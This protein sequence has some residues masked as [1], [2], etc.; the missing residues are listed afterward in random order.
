[1]K[2][3]GLRGK[4]SI[5]VDRTPSHRVAVVTAT[6]S[7]VANLPAVRAAGE[8]RGP[9][10]AEAFERRYAAH[11]SS[12]AVL[13][14]E[15]TA[16]LAAHDIDDPTV[17]PILLCADEAFI[18]AVAHAAGSPVGVIA[19]LQHDRVTLQVT[20]AGPGFDPSQIDVAA[21]PDLMAEHGR[22]LFLIHSLMDDVEILSDQRGTTLHMERDV[23]RVRSSAPAFT[24][25]LAASQEVAAA[26]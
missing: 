8:S 25:R 15:L 7:S 18:N 19:D 4:Q 1:M 20:D 22:G 24:S 13:R 26:S 6:W 23:S 14:T 12:A 3:T 11:P 2:A 17:S 10:A 16:Y 5:T 9:A 21:R